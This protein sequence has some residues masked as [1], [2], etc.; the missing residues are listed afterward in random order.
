MMG[1]LMLLLG[2]AGVPSTA[3]A[4]LQ[5]PHYAQHEQTGQHDRPTASSTIVAQAQ[6]QI[7]WTNHQG[8]ECP[9]CPAF[10]CARV[11]PCAGSLTAIAPSCK[12]IADPQG[13]RVV[14]D[15]LRQVA[16]SAVPAPPSPPP[17]L[18]A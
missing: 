7:A 9:H 11:S 4:A 15:R 5:R 17:Q 13:H 6:G 10:E 18:I 14:I 16:R 1:L 12:A 3:S 8:H 2:I